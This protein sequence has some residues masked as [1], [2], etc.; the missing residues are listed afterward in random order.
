LALG[1]TAQP[2][3]AAASA[4]ARRDPLLAMYAEWLAVR[5]AIGAA[6]DHP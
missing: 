2:E 5:A 1:V 3:A 6:D 4:V